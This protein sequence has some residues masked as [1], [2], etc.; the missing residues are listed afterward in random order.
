MKIISCIVMAEMLGESE[1]CIFMSGIKFYMEPHTPTIL[2]I[3]RNTSY[4]KII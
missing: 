3:S 4:I 1:Y 2:E